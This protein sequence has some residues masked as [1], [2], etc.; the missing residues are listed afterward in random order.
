MLNQ[1][2]FL[3][4]VV[5]NGIFQEAARHLEKTQVDSD[6]GILCAE[7]KNSLI[8]AKTGIMREGGDVGN[9][10]QQQRQRRFLQQNKYPSRMNIKHASYYMDHYMNEEAFTLD[11]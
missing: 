11:I 1:L 3:V 5:D 10:T 2:V 4:D 9:Q 6:F 8:L 7:L